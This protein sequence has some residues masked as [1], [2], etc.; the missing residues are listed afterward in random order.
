[1]K[2][3]KSERCENSEKLQ[4]W[5]KK[6]EKCEARLFMTPFEPR[7]RAYWIQIDKKICTN[8]TISASAIC[9]IK[10]NNYLQKLSLKKPWNLGIEILWCLLKSELLGRGNPFF[11]I[12]LLSLL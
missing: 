11:K 12:Y 4:L 1:M 9:H 5:F 6:F 3:R 2:K 8:Y 7:W 10:R